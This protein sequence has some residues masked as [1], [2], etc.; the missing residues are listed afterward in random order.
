MI[1]QPTPISTL[2][3]WHRA[4]LA[5]LRPPVHEGEP[6]CG[7]FKTRLAKGGPFVPAVIRLDRDIDPATGELASPERIVCEVNG[8]PR[9]AWDAWGSLC[10]SPISREEYRDLQ[11]LQARYPQMAGTHAAI[12]IR[13]EDIRP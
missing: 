4:A 13:P 3:A 8:Q 9:N 10:K 7:W 5:G 6:Q 11:D 1:R 12:D 2:Y